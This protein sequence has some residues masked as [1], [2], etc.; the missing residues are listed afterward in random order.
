M[1][2][3]WH[4]IAI[5]IP[6]FI[7]FLHELTYRS[8]RRRIFTPDGSNDADSCKDVPFVGFVDIA[9]HLGSEIPTNPQ[10]LG[11]NRRFKLNGQNIESF[12]LSK[13]P[14]LQRF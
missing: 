7:P 11:V 8:D 1:F 9:P 10:F 2:T 12:M 14:V 3:P 6:L 13:L 5:S 4:R